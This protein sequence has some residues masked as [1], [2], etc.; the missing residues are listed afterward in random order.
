VGAG[1]TG[2]SAGRSEGTVHNQGALGAPWAIIGLA[3]PMQIDFAFSDLYAKTLN[4][5][6]NAFPYYLLFYSK[7]VFTSLRSFWIRITEPELINQI[8]QLS[9]QEPKIYFFRT[10]F[11]LFI[12]NCLLCGTDIA[13]IDM[14]PAS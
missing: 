7:Y 4:P 1:H 14:R 8:C 3:R 5:K 2:A 6:I 13:G 10:L 12:Y 11:E 9:L